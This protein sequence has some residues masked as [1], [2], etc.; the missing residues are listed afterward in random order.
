MRTFIALVVIVYLVGV[1]V[2]LSPTVQAKWASAPASELFTSVAQAL[3]DAVA[4]PAR[5][6]HSMADRPVTVR[7]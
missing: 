3:P 5:A 4:W 6:Y 7:G 1:G 2:A